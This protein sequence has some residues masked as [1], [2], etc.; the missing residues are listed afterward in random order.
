[1]LVCSVWLVHTYYVRQ[2][3]NI[4]NIHLKY[5]GIFLI[6]IHGIKKKSEVSLW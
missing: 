4:K 1:M 2:E 3:S 5:L 6:T